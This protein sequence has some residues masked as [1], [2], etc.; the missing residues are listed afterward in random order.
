MLQKYIFYSE[1]Q[2]VLYFPFGKLAI[3]HSAS[4]QF[5]ILELYCSQKLDTN[6]L[7]RKEP[8]MEETNIFGKKQTIF[9]LFNTYFC[10]TKC[11]QRFA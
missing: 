2:N 5:L 7:G 4:W 9:L 8:K 1:Y 3:F 11:E 6:I 10:R